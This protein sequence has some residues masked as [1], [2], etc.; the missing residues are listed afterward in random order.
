MLHVGGARTALFNWA[1][2]RRHGGRFVLRVEDTDP[3][4]SRPEYETAILEGLRWLGL[5]WDEGPD[6]G[7][8]HGPYRQSE[9]FDTY[10]AAAAALAE[11]SSAYRCFCS[12]ERLAE[13][14]ERQSAAKATPR[15]DGRCR[16]LDAAEATRRAAAGEPSV[17]RFRVPAGETRFADL[18]RGD[19][20]F[21]N[22]E[23][24][25]WIMV[26]TD[27][28][29]TYNFVVVCDDVAMEISHVLRAEEHLTNTPKQVLLYRALGHAAPEF[30]HLPLMLGKDKK[31]LSKRTGDTA[32]Q[33]YRDNGHPPEAMLNFLALQGWALDDKTDVF[34]AAT[35]CAHFDPAQ[36]SK[37]GAVFDPEKLLWMAG[38]YVRMDATERVADRCMP[39]LAAEGLVNPA[40]VAAGGARRGWYVAAIAL[41]QERIQLYSE[42]PAKLAWLFAGDGAVAFDATAEKGA[43]KHADAAATLAEYRAWLLPR[44]EGGVDADALREASKAWVG[45]RGLKIPALFQPLRLALTGAGGGP[46]LFDVMALLGAERTLARI[47]AGA[48][49]LA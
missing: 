20:R 32:L 19:V 11:G 35:L 44:I 46:D 34:D 12:A 8:D 1:F 17:L 31:K 36:G 2:A 18:I 7:G 29:P 6:V 21:D 30:G 10:R 16:E 27:G 43:R 47:E 45:E 14:R 25:D 39:F 26:R 37:A 24:D 22:A 9:R 41:I 5:D 40:E 4:R 15:Y 33:D 42:A 23:V 38:E 28:S 13:M 48:R 3:E 49:R